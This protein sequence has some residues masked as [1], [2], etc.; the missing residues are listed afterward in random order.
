M[1]EYMIALF[2]ANVS[3]KK[4]DQVTVGV[5]SNLTKRDIENL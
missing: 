2:S 3:K 5:L 4:I 1:F